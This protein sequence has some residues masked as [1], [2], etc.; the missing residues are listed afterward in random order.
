[1]IRSLFF[2]EGFT[3]IIQPN[4]ASPEHNADFK[5]VE[6]SGGEGE[7]PNETRLYGANAE[8]TDV[9]RGEVV[10]DGF[11]KWDG[12]INW[13]T[14]PGA[15]K[16]A[17]HVVEMDNIGPAIS[18]AVRLA[19]ASVPAYYVEGGDEAR[20]LRGECLKWLLTPGG[21]DIGGL[22]SAAGAQLDVWALVYGL[23]REA[24]EADATLR[25]RVA[26]ERGEVVILA[27]QKQTG[28]NTGP[29]IADASGEA[30]DHIAGVL[31]RERFLEESDE[32]LRAR[33]RRLEDIR[34]GAG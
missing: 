11:V 28:W 16:H 31:G 20:R 14:P 33:L 22:D 32:L 3:I 21:G 6:A 2:V 34:N 13:L 15:Y 5:I 23:R 1:M 18:A 4:E 25:L 12:C 8:E 27:T 9:D 30:L 10:I 26:K 29:M 24:A 17:C 7:A 19:C